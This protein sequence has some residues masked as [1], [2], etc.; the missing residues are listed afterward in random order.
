MRGLV[1]VVLVGVVVGCNDV[2]GGGSVAVVDVAPAIGVGVDEVVVV[3][4]A[5]A[6]ARLVGWLVGWLGSLVG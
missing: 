5:V 4:V 3:V 6:V 1:V 2:V